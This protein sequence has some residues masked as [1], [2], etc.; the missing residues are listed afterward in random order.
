[1]RNCFQYPLDGHSETSN[2]QAL[3]NPIY[4]YIN[5]KEYIRVEGMG[6]FPNG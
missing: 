3:H 2:D 4:H 1:M 6:H 5:M